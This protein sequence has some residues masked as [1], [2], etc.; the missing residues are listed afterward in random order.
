MKE[1]SEQEELI[2]K[3]ICSQR[4]GLSYLHSINFYSPISFPC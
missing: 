2:L 4:K 3:E 1:K